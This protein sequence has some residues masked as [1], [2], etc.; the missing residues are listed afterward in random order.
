MEF[1][2]LC[3]LAYFMTRAESFHHREIS[4]LSSIFRSLSLSLSRLKSEKFTK[5]RTAFNT[6][7]PLSPLFLMQNSPSP[8]FSF[9]S[10]RFRSF[11]F[12]MVGHPIIYII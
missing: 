5:S 4:H 7:H 9:L 1:R 6:P 2:D 11:S 12:H 10:F 3:V 8:S